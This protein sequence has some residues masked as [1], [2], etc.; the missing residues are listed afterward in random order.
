MTPKLWGGIECSHVHLWDRTVDQ[1]DLT[2]HGD[3][4]GDLDL[5]AGL[6]L[7][8][9]R[10]PLLRD[11]IAPGLIADADWSWPDE[12]LRLLGHH[13]I[14][15]VVTLQHHGTRH[16]DTDLRDDRFASDLAD[17]AGAVARRYPWLRDYT[18]VN[19]PLTTA[20]FSCLYG[21]WFPHVQSQHS[22]L[23]AVVVQVKATILCMQ[24]VREVNREARLIY[25]GELGW[26]QSTPALRYQ[27]DFENERRWLA[28][29]L[30]CG[31]VLPGH[32]FYD[33]LLA[34]GLS[35]ADLGWLEENHC[36]P[37]VLGCDYYPTS[38]RVLDERL[39]LYPQWSHGGNDF[40]AY[41]DVHAALAEDFRPLGLEQ[42]LLIAWE[43]YGLK[44]AIT[45][46]HLNGPAHARVAWLEHALGVARNLGARG[47][48]IEAVCAWALF[49]TQDW[50]SLLTE[51]N[52]FYE[53]G[54]F[55]VRGGQPVPTALA[56]TIRRM[57]RDAAEAVPEAPPT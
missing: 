37:D 13:G 51:D 17:Y 15:P 6:G 50:D 39:Q 57:T 33:Q 49:G 35:E 11:R 20:R 42:T 29:D 46:V 24:R 34:A 56:D 30:L 21:H 27:A 12:R 48:P 31:R 47:V 2:G 38:E 52:G 43:R 9:L 45:E 18:P 7:N 16:L 19:E 44:L 14:R 10:Y 55:D 3:R 36:P 4:P 54:A 53:P 23:R 28:L 22:F 32:P 25:T 41:A 5:V 26:T 8:V 40:E 1:L